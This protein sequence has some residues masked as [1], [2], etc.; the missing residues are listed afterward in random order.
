MCFNFVPEILFFCNVSIT[1]Q[2]LANMLV[3]MTAGIETSKDQLAVIMKRVERL[4]DEQKRREAQRNEASIELK[5]VSGAL[6]NYATSVSKLEEYRP[7]DKLSEV[8]F[9]KKINIRVSPPY[10]RTGSIPLAQTL[11]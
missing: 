5:S 9:E 7:R 11:P 2:V 3:T 4:E 1:V 6:D 10:P 8:G